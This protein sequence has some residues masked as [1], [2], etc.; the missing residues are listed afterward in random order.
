MRMPY[1]RSSR[2]YWSL[3]SCATCGHVAA[4]SKGPV[5]GVEAPRRTQQRRTCMHARGSASRHAVGHAWPG[6]GPRRARTRTHCAQDTHA[7]LLHAGTRA[8]L[9]A[10]QG[11]MGST[12]CTR[13]RSCS[14]AQPLQAG[15]WRRPRPDA[16]TWQ[17]WT[18]PV[19]TLSR[20]LAVCALH[21]G[22]HRGQET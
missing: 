8:H 5:S 21:M 9:S 4:A 13:R 16:Q 19:R 22:G 10:A 7:H 20:A 3:R 18:Q 17:T 15:V 14:R 2:T 6:P 1:A 11:G 12:G